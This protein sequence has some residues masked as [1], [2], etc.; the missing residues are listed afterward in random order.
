LRSI[1]KIHINT[2]RDALPIPEVY[3]SCARQRQAAAGS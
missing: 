2:T 3:S 1:P